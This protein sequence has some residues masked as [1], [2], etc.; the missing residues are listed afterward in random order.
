L[1]QG[2]AQALHAVINLPQEL[3][4]LKALE[5]IQ[6]EKLKELKYEEY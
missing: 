6:S 5:E 1:I 4:E 2:K 3:R